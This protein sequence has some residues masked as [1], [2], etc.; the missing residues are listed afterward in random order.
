MGEAIYVYVY[1][2]KLYYADEF[3]LLNPKPKLPQNGKDGTAFGSFELIKT[4]TCTGHTSIIVIDIDNND[5][6]IKRCCKNFGLKNK[7]MLKK[8]MLLLAY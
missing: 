3:N 5:L 1:K 8:S 6:Y 2:T 4:S 7:N